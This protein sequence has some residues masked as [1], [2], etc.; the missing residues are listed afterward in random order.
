[1]V[2]NLNDL[3]QDEAL[4][5]G[6][7][8]RV[9]RSPSVVPSGSSGATGRKSAPSTVATEESSSLSEEEE[10]E[11]EEEDEVQQQDD[12]V[13]GGRRGRRRRRRRRRGRGGWRRGR[14]SMCEAIRH[15]QNDPYYPR[16]A[17][18]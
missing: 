14:R 16:T 8:R 12:E 10:E 18:Y 13:Q 3:Y 6:M 15:F 9:S 11:E 5:S 1:L 2:R 7:M 17:R 4:G